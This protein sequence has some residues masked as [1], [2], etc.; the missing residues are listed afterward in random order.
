[1]K[2]HPQHFVFWPWYQLQCSQLVGPQHPN[3]LVRILRQAKQ[4]QQLLRVKQQLVLRQQ[5]QSQR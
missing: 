5:K 3:Q 1:M 4:V 2:N